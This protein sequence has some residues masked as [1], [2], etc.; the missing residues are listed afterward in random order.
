MIEKRVFCV[1]I[2]SIIV[3]TL[4][5]GSE[6]SSPMPNSPDMSVVDQADESKK[7]RADIVQKRLKKLLSPNLLR[8]RLMPKP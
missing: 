7:V 1:A 3:V 8:S 4:C 6:E 2:I 5:C